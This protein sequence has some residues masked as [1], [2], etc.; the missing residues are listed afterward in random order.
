M[1]SLRR[2]KGSLRSHQHDALAVLDDVEQGI[3]LQED[4]W[5]SAVRLLE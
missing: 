5:V 3:V 4:V 1:L 2:G